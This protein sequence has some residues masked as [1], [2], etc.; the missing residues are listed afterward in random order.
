LFTRL[1]TLVAMDFYHL[2]GLSSS[3]IWFEVT[4]LWSICLRIFR[5]WPVH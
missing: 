3:F 4:V 2:E 1:E 5:M